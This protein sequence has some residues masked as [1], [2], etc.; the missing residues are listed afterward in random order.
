MTNNFLKAQKGKNSPPKKPN[1]K[2]RTQY[3]SFFASTH[4]FRTFQDSALHSGQRGRKRSIA[5]PHGNAL[6][7]RKLTLLENTAA[8]VPSKVTEDRNRQK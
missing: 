6:L 7:T 1:K 8:S 4:D 3:S 2:Q 5:K